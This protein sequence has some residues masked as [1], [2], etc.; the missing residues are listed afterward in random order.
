MILDE[1]VVR[2][3]LDRHEHGNAARER[4]ILLPPG[5][6]HDGRTVTAGGFHKRV[7]Y[8]DTT[9]LPPSLVGAAVDVPIHRDPALRDRLSTLHDTLGGGGD[10][11]EAESRLAFVAERLLVHLRGETVTPVRGVSRTESRL[12]R[13]MRDLLDTRVAE[14]LLLT[15]AAE[16]LHATPTHLVRVFSRAYGLPPHA[17]LTNRRIDRARGL[18]L[19]GMK[20]ADVATEVGFHDQSHLHRHFVRFLGVPPGQYATGKA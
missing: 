7:L 10:P 3:D 4:V 9:V 14:G 8:L 18:L 19:A 1:G 2:F 20:A 12:A 16:M 15:Q 13:E 17:Y 6:P 5:V 11:L